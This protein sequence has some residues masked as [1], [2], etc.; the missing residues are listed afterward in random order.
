M[1]DRLYAHLAAEHNSEQDDAADIAQYAHRLIEG[2]CA[3]LILVRAEAGFRNQWQDSIATST[4]CR[5]PLVIRPSPM[6]HGAHAAT[7][8]SDCLFFQPCRAQCS[9]G[10][11]NR[12]SR[13]C[14]GLTS[15]PDERIMGAG[16]SLPNPPVW[17]PAAE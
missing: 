1:L 8:R 2:H 17:R 6:A 9:F 11:S 10:N 12:N 4:N 16:I 14:Y 5:H 13:V 3:G 15:N 7:P